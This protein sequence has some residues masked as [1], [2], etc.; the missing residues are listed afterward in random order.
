MNEFCVFQQVSASPG[1]LL[2]GDTGRPPPWGIQRKCPHFVFGDTPL[3][4]CMCGYVCAQ[5]EWLKERSVSREEKASF[6]FEFEFAGR[7]N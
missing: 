3:F 1:L 5:T 2:S 7:N 6:V 4:V